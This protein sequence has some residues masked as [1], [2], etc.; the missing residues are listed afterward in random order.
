MAGSKCNINLF[1]DFLILYVSCAILPIEAFPCPIRY[2]TQTKK[3]YE[4]I[5][6]TITT[7]RRNLILTVYI[8]KCSYLF[9]FNSNNCCS[10]WSTRYK[11]SNCTAWK[12]LYNHIHTG[13]DNIYQCNQLRYKSSF[14]LSIA[15]FCF[16]SLKNNL[17]LDNWQVVWGQQ[18]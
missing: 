17:M 15:S 11:K 13:H 18:I 3:N 9:R 7:L 2:A 10:S 14:I 4:E 1:N 6:F 5:I 8:S 16:L 12:S